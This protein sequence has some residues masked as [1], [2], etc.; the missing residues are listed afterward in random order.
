M[1][2]ENVFLRIMQTMRRCVARWE[3]SGLKKPE[4]L[5]L[6][7]YQGLAVKHSLCEGYVQQI[8]SFNESVLLTELRADLIT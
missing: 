5:G 4:L 1:G 2:M 7:A 3:S 6:V 8:Q